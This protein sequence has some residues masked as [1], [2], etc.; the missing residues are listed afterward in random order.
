MIEV[1]TTNKQKMINNIEDNSIERVLAAKLIKEQ[2]YNKK[3]LGKES[4][5][6]EFF[7]DYL[8]EEFTLEPVFGETFCVDKINVKMISKSKTFKR[9]FELDRYSD[10][11]FQKQI[12]FISKKI[13]E[14]AVKSISLDNDLQSFA[15]HSEIMS[16]YFEILELT[17]N[18]KVILYNSII[19]KSGSIKEK[20]H[21]LLIKDF[22]DIYIPEI[23]EDRTRN[24]MDYKNKKFT[25]YPSYG[26][27]NYEILACEFY[28]PDDIID[29]VIEN[30]S[31]YRKFGNK[32]FF[33]F[34]TFLDTSEFNED[35]INRLRLEL[36]S[37]MSTEKLDQVY[38][39][40]LYKKV[41]GLK[42]NR[43]VSL[44]LLNINSQPDASFYDIL[45]TVN[46]DD[47]SLMRYN[48]SIMNLETY[49]LKTIDVCLSQSV[50]VN[51]DQHLI[52][53]IKLE[54]KTA[55]FYSENSVGIHSEEDIKKLKKEVLC[56]EELIERI[57]ERVGNQK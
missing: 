36:N 4:L 25:T 39:S 34:A 15:M 18:S 33:D 51:I 8:K 16:G 13:K 14:K 12:D 5:D 2:I 56:A 55:K 57:A 40:E 7:Y 45:G 54:I 22:K 19:N 29:Y 48:S 10:E 32:K 44:H 42:I 31:D 52:E 3:Y 21:P 37:I 38:N 35:Q 53:K 27:I 23:L 49:D 30:K 6:T 26:R 20:L 41:P 1:I 47:F 43:E 46:V 17:M 11:L 28:S 9:L 50:C 24:V